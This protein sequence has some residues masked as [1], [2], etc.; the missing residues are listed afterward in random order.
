MGTGATFY[1]D[2][3]SPY[4]YLAAERIDGLLP[5]AEWKPIAFAIL[6]NQLGVLEKR[7]TGTDRDAV[8][9]EVSER[10]SRRG[11]PPFVPPDVWPIRSWSLVPLRAAVFAEEIGRQR[12]FARA[13]FH[14][15]FARGRSL[16]E[17]GN[18]LDSAR[19][20][21]LDPDEVEAA[22]QRPEVKDRLKANTDEALARG[23]TGIPT[24]VLGDEVFWGDDRLEEAVAA[25]GARR[26]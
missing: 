6:L 4:A 24:V 1:F 20:A 11:L 3:N 9:R 5:D 21:G 26:P 16:A 13:A 22:I 2:F 19:A 12:E 25:A 17:L 18:V 7:I 14:T 15:A 8:A 10:V 23:V